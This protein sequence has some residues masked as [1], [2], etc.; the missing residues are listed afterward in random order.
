MITLELEPQLLLHIDLPVLR[1]C[2]EY[3]TK[4]PLVSKIY[5]FA[6]KINAHNN[7]MPDTF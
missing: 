6:S 7:N 4:L 2:K 1:I 3:F 5:K